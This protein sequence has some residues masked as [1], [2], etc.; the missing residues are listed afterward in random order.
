MEINYLNKIKINKDYNKKYY[1]SYGWDNNGTI[2]IDHNSD[3]RPILV[4][5]NE[6]VIDILLNGFDKEIR[7]FHQFRLEEGVHEI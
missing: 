3:Y 7:E 4:V 5:E 6:M 1:I 2:V